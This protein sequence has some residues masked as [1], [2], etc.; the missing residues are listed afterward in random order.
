MG[1]LPHTL[2]SSQAPTRPPDHPPRHQARKHLRDEG[3]HGQ[4]RRSRPLQDP[5]KQV[6][7]DPPEGGNPH[8]LRP[9]THPAPAVRLPDR[10]LG[11]G[12]R[13]LPP[14]ELVS[15][16]RRSYVGDS[17]AFR[18]SPGTCSS[19]E[20]HLQRSN[21]QMDSGAARSKSSN[22]SRHRQSHS[23][24]R[25]RGNRLNQKSRVRLQLQDFNCNRGSVAGEVNKYGQEHLT[26]Y[27][28][29]RRGTVGYHLPPYE[30]QRLRE[31]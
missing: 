14:Y 6:V 23:R 1:A 20:L 28:L 29:E 12:L 5:R 18:A 11:L 17:R 4:A 24:H 27:L 13:L 8:L 15:S 25:T 26:E 30:S 2:R 16:L 7:A 10:R 22:S 3:S 19:E 9:G 21:G 31:G